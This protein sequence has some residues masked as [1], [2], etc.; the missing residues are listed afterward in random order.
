MLSTGVS[1]TEY[2]SH[3]HTHTHTP[4]THTHTYFGKKKKQMFSIKLA[5]T[6]G[7]FFFHVTLSLQTYICLLYICLSV[8][9]SLRQRQYMRKMCRL[10]RR[11]HMK[12]FHMLTSFICFLFGFHSYLFFLVCFISSVCE[13]HQSSKMYF[14][15]VY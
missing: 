15:S 2:G 13:C 10:F 12:G 14:L 1:L 7:F 4:H 8:R 6:V 3:T 9:L 11:V 5:A